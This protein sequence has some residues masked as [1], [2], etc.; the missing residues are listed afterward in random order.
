M[1]NGKSRRKERELKEN[2][3]LQE[4]KRTTYPEQS[5]TM[6]HKR[7]CNLYQTC[8]QE[9]TTTKETKTYKYRNKVKFK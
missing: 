6:I 2:T 8:N 9:D 5:T 4:V 1:Q 3:M 7:T